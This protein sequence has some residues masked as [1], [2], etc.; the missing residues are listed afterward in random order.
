MFTY[1]TIENFRGIEQLTVSGMGRVNLII[2]KNDAGKT[3]LMEAVWMAGHAEDA[4]RAL[5]TLQEMR[6][7]DV[8]VEDFDGFWR[9]IFRGNDAE[10]GFLV[11]ARLMP[12][13]QARGAGTRV[14]MS[15]ARRSP[16]LSGTEP[17]GGNPRA[18]TW[19]LECSIEREGETH[20]QL[21]TGS[22]RGVEFPDEVYPE[23]LG[24]WIPSGSVD[25]RNAI[26]LFSRLKQEGQDSLV[27]ELM[28]LIDEQVEGVEILSPTGGQAALFVRLKGQPVLL[29]IRL[30]GEGV[31]R[32]FDIAVT[33]ASGEAL[34]L[35]IDEI[36]NGLHHSTLEPVWKWL[37]TVS[38]ARSMQ[39]FATTHSEE[40]VQAACRAFSALD[41]PGL[42]V[43]RLDRRAHETVAT[44]YDRNL[45]A[46]AERMGVEIRG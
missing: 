24:T 41:D 35:G 7:P 11:D 36:E 39:I 21:V 38:A 43:I 5:W 3:A 18:G 15:K 22:P 2:G 14:Q 26:R 8:P 37:A 10:R 42:R 34:L 40:C 23:S 19:A 31:Q 32:C 29:P 30:M 1:A 27:R 46:A 44:V 17:A 16:P 33:L 25:Y 12:P 20:E 28:R 45:V 13:G 4:A 6:I 9:P